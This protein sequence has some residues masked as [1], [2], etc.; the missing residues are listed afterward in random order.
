MWLFTT[1]TFHGGPIPICSGYLTFALWNIISFDKDNNRRSTFW[2]LPFH[3][4]V[5]KM[6]FLYLTTMGR[7]DTYNKNINLSFQI[8][9]TT[10]NLWLQDLKMMKMFC[11]SRRIAL[12]LN[13][14]H[15]RR[16]KPNKELLWIRFSK[17]ILSLRNKPPISTLVANFLQMAGFCNTW[18]AE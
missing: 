7:T 3:Q 12:I 8:V 11:I 15:L 1:I 6:C 16:V 2:E 13:S 4:K 9:G 5:G 18:P 14:A 10:W 17:K